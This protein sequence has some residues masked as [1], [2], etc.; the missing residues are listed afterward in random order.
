MPTMRKVQL[1]RWWTV[2]PVVIVLAFNIFSRKDVS[3]DFRVVPISDLVSGQCNL[4]WIR[5][6]CRMADR[7][8]SRPWD[9]S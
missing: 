2:P 7:L 5:L 8:L 3:Y 6:R 1:S 9:N 4:V